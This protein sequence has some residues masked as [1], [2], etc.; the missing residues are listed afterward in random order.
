MD[1]KHEIKDSFCLLE[2]HLEF[3]LTLRCNT[4]IGRSLDFTVQELVALIKS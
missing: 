2:A 1:L 4:R 3:Q